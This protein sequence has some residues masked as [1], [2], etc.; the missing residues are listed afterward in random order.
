MSLDSE[1]LVWYLVFFS[2]YEFFV[3]LF[4][5]E[6]IKVMYYMFFHNHFLDVT[7]LT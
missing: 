3:Y 2:S 5:D 6:E 1:I 4:F 7:W